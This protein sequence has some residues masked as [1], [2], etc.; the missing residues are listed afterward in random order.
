M[1]VCASLSLLPPPQHPEAFVLDLGDVQYQRSEP[2]Q[3]RKGSRWV[4]TESERR[5]TMSQYCSV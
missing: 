1:G 5:E 4:Q 3:E 2:E